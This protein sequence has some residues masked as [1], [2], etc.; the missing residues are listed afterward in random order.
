[1]VHGKTDPFLAFKQVN[2]EVKPA[3]GKLNEAINTN[4]NDCVDEMRKHLGCGQS[5]VRI[6]KLEITKAKELRHNVGRKVIIYNTDQIKS[7]IANLK[8]KK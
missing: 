2:P 8:H 1:M 4:F 3:L 7:E 5:Q 6:A